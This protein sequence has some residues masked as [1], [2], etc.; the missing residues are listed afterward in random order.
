MEQQ[1]KGKI[2]CLVDIVCSLPQVGFEVASIATVAGGV[3][4]GTVGAGVVALVYDWRLGATMAVG[5]LATAGIA[6]Y[7]VGMYGF[8]VGFDDAEMGISKIKKA[9]QE[10]KR[11]NL[12]KSDDL[13]E[14]SHSDRGYF[15][16]APDSD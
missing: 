3:V 13:K 1:T 15:S 4:T 8:F 14:P 11:I 7:A 16:K 6:V 5:G 2:K 9:V 10:Y 12:A